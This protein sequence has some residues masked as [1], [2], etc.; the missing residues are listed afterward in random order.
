M[1]L[2]RST[3]FG[4]ALLGLS[5]TFSPPEV[6]AQQEPISTDRPDQAESAVVVGPGRVQIETGVSLTREDGQDYTSFPTLLRLGAGERWEFRLESDILHLQ[7]PGADS[8]SDVVVG[9][10]V[11][12]HKSEGRAFGLLLDLAIPAGIEDVR[13]S[14][15]PE[16]KA[17]LDQDLGGDFSLSLNAGLSVPE[18]DDA[19]LVSYTWAASLSHPV[20]EKVD[21]YLEL[22]GEG[23]DQVSGPGQV[24]VDSGF[25]YQPNNDLQFDVSYA[26]GLSSFGL[27]WSVGLGVSTRF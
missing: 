24:G 17:L 18:D 22:F 25:T 26:K 3:L 12:L 7:N 1:R 14:L 16:I 23:P 10:K 15:E 4:V 5:F 8:F 21:V 13:G 2:F 9:A 19:R 27:D 6:Q 20:S 11:I